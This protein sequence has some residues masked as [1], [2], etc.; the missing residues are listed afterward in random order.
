LRLLEIVLKKYKSRS[1]KIASLTAASNITGIT[2]DVV[3]ITRLLHC[4]GF[5][6]FWDYAAAASYDKINMKPS[7]DLL[8]CPD[9]VFF[10]GHKFIGGAGNSGILTFRTNQIIKKLNTPI[11]PS[12]GTVEIVSSRKTVYI[13]DV[14]EREEGG[15]FSIVLIIRISFNSWGH[16][17][18][19]GHGSHVEDRL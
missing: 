6:V 5:L 16:T 11:V 17:I 18:G 19:N 1:L 2:C 10:S 13:N 14:I 3:S 12:G 8:D 15:L 9:A 4:Y 7:H